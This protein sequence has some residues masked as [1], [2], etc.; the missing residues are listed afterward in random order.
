MDY[1]LFV[2]RFECFADALHDGERFIN[3]N[4]SSLN[5]VG[6]GFTFHQ[7]EHQEAQV[8]HFFKVVNGSDVR[9]V[10]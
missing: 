6:Q 8:I 2:G 5:T 7:F 10:Q 3:R 4:G 9:M 1:A